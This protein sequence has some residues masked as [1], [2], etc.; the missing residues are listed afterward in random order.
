MTSYLV[1]FVLHA[2]KL[3]IW[4]WIAISRFDYT[5]FSWHFGVSELFPVIGVH[6]GLNY[7]ILLCSNLCAF[8]VTDKVTCIIG[9]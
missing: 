5:S 4:V 1:S 3:T 9:L 2:K 7:V 6:F 8:E